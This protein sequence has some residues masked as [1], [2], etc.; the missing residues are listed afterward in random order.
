[1]STPNLVPMKHKTDASNIEECKDNTS[2]VEANSLTSKP[3]TPPQE[4][5]ID[6]FR[7][8]AKELCKDHE[9]GPGEPQKQCFFV[10]IC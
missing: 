1:M 8:D 3:V 10:E 4:P 5:N 2:L 9:F 7:P 6:Y